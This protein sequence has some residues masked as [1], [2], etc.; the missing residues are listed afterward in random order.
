[1]NC[2]IEAVCEGVVLG[3]HLISLHAPAAYDSWVD[4]HGNVEARTRY[5]TVTPGAYVVL[6]NG[7]TL[8]AYRN[9]YGRASVYAGWTFRTEGDRFALTVGAVTGYGRFPTSPVW[10]GEDGQNYRTYHSGQDVEPLIVPSVR[11]GLTD[12][13][14]LRVGLLA[15]PVK[16]G[17]AALHFAIE[18]RLN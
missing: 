6:G 10:P 3:A 9:S 15:R 12:S 4:H 14:S 1:M 18:T 5:E 8:G 7:A 2:L 16:D 11:F 17:A 13:T